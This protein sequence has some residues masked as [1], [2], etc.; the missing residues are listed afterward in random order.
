MTIIGLQ[1]EKWPWTKLDKLMTLTSKAA[2]TT[3]RIAL[4]YLSVKPV[5]VTKV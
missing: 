1:M 2:F 3:C 5:L 4:D